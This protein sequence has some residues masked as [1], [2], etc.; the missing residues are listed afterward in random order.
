MPRRIPVRKNGLPLLLIPLATAAL[1]GAA[2]VAIGATAG[3]GGYSYY[4]GKEEQ[5]R[6]KN[7]PKL[8][9]ELENRIKS[10]EMNIKIDESVPTSLM[11]APTDEGQVALRCAWVYAIAAQRNPQFKND[12]LAEAKAEL[13][14]Y[15]DEAGFFISYDNPY[16]PALQQPYGVEIE[17]RCTWYQ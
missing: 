1:K 11:V 6:R 14:Y 13:Q 8:A 16:D 17:V 10:I 2:I 3:V 7:L 4:V 15:K 5:E 12:L 9:I